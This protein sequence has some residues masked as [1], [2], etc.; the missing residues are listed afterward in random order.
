MYRINVFKVLG[1][2]AAVVFV[3]SQFNSAF[4]GN[5][6]FGGENE[7]HFWQVNT[8]FCTNGFTVTANE[9]DHFGTPTEIGDALPFSLQVTASSPAS[10]SSLPAPIA[11]GFGGPGRVLASGTATFLFSQPQTVGTSVTITVERWDHGLFSGDDDSTVP[12]DHSDF[13]DI[14]PSSGPVEN[15][16]VSVDTTAPATTAAISPA[17]NANGWN[18]ADV[19]VQLNAADN[20]GG[21]GVKMID[22]QGSGAQ[23]IS[24]TMNFGNP[25]NIPLS[26]EG[27]TTLTYFAWDNA[28]NAE[29]SHTLAVDI[30]KSAPNISISSPQGQDYAHTANLTTAWVSADSLSGIATDSGKLDG[31]PVSNG[32]AVDLFFLS[33]GQH[34]LAVNASDK[35]GNTTQASVTFNV[36]ATLDSLMD[37]TNRA[38]SLGWIS[39]AGICTSLRVELKAAQAASKRGSLVAA[40]G[41]LKAYLNELRAQNGKAVNQQ[42]Y[43]LLSTD[44]NYVLQHLSGS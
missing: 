43:D 30:D 22:Y 37:A 5:F 11:G 16:T 6:A 39:K 26:A 21:L 3:I 24:Q 18:K 25:V 23:P 32:Q 29:A 2:A 17:P 33:L 44:A 19:T 8:Q 15:C 12:P 1:L 10:A 27:A 40:R 7:D 20:V 38:C 13:D 9:T 28:G 31:N 34:T 35:A 41:L 42:A 36:V 14:L 4:A